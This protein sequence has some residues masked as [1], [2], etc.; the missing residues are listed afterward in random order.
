MDI[1]YNLSKFWQE[2]IITFG[3]TQALIHFNMSEYKYRAYVFTY[4]LNFSNSGNYILQIKVILAT[5]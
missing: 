4:Y 3:V 1:V 5:I 2:F